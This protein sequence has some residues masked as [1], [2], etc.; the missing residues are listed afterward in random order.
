[1]LLKSNS[2]SS[3]ISK[4]N[5]FDLNEAIEELSNFKKTLKHKENEKIYIITNNIIE[6]L[7]KEFGIDF[8]KKINK[9]KI[10]EKLKNEIVK[11]KID[12]EIENIKVFNEAEEIENENIE[13]VN[14]YFLLNLGVN[15][16]IL[17][18]KEIDFRVINNKKQQVLFKDG[19]TR[20][21]ILIKKNK[22]IFRFI[23][24]PTIE[25]NINNDKNNED[26]KNNENNE[27]HDLNNKSLKIE[28]SIHAMLGNFN[29]NENENGNGNLDDSISQ[30]NELRININHNSLN[31]NL[32]NFLREIKKIYI[33]QIKINDLLKEP[34]NLEKEYNNYLIVN[35]KWFNRLSKIFEDDKKYENEDELITTF[36]N[37]SKSNSID[38]INKDLFELDLECE[39]R[40]K[41]KYPKD[42]ILIEE[43]SLE[44]LNLHLNYD[45]N[46]NKYTMLF[47][48]N[49]L[50]IKDKEDNK[51]IFACSKDN[52]FFS[53][54]ILFKYNDEGYFYQEI[55]D[56]VHNRGGNTGGS[57]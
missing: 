47:G 49:Y 34:I 17:K 23:E 51:N 48:D 8:Y 24:G 38:K 39:K 46:K 42:F 16:K 37:I 25:K 12:K 52:F 29:V 36:K 26:I 2:E 56:Y 4:N 6:Y 20:L 40:L 18:D 53:V 13:I 57:R 41:I 32:N 27:N 3:L 54:N 14:E 44:N 55:N 50:F 7:K 43:N 33:Q 1:M 21:N 45:I 31:M 9:D 15:E 28:N 22:N 5:K 35:K 10:A 19:G 30:N 11:E